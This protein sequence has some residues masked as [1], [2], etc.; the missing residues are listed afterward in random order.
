M[1]PCFAG[2]HAWQF[3][4]SSSFSNSRTWDTSFA[5]KTP[6]TVPVRFHSVRVRRRYCH[7]HERR[8]P[9]RG[10][11]G[12][13]ARLAFFEQT[14]TL[15]RC[16]S[17]ASHCGRSKAPSVCPDVRCARL[18]SKMPPP[19]WSIV[20]AC[21]ATASASSTRPALKA[22]SSSAAAKQLSTITWP[23]KYR[24]KA[25]AFATLSFASSCCPN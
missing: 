11:C 13:Q 10:A 22:I 17:A 18:A 21:S 5:V 3:P 20:T 8:C 4:S 15:A 14:Q 23:P 2:D 24:A 7:A 19:D 25:L 6:Q 1:L 16:V 12:F 9:M